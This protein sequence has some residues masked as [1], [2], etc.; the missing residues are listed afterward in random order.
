M[1]VNTVISLPASVITA[2]VPVVSATFVLVLTIAIV[3]LTWQ[4]HAI[5]IKKI[6]KTLTLLNIIINFNADMSAMLIPI[7]L[8]DHKMKEPMN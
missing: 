7:V 3:I 2:Y 6:K 1:I 5:V 8:T 4:R